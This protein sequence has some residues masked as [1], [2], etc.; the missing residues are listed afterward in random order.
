MLWLL[1]SLP[2]LAVDQDGDGWHLPEDCQD[3]APSVHPTAPEVPVDGLDQD[4][5]GFDLCYWDFDGDGYGEQPPAG[6]P[7]TYKVDNDLNCGNLSAL[8]SVSADDCDDRDASVGPGAEEVVGD[9]IDQDCDGVDRCYQDLDDDGYGSERAVTGLDLDC[10]DPS[11]YTASRA[12]DCDDRPDVGAPHNPGAEDVCDGL[13]NNCD[14]RIDELASPDALTYFFDADQ[15][16]WG[17]AELTAQACG[18]LVGYALRAGDCDDEDPFISPG[19]PEV[20]G[21]NLDNDCDDLEEACPAVDDEAERACGCGALGGAYAL[22]LP[23]VAW[24]RRRQRR[25]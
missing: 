9:G 1:L 13:D 20:C 23:V 4:C 24:P 21:D 17:T 3:Q 22:L 10:D 8:T 5:D 7:P 18:Q 25:L 2:A 19:E 16:G 15:D 11:V 12:G 6:Q 14:G